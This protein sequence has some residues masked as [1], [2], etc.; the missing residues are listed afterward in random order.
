MKK[1]KKRSKGFLNIQI[2]SSEGVHTCVIESPGLW[3]N[4]EELGNIVKDLRRIVE[5]LGIGDLDYGIFT[6]SKDSLDRGVITVIYDGPKKN[7]LAFNSMAFIPCEIQG[8]PTPVLHLGLTVVDP[9]VQSKGFTWTLYGLSTALLLLKNR[10]RPF[11]I[12]S[13]TQVPVV[14]GKVADNLSE[15]YPAATP[16]SRRTFQHLLLGRQIMKYH[17]HVFGVGPDAEFDEENFIICNAYTGGSDHLK[18]T[19]KECAQYRHD[20]VNEFCLKNLN[21]QRGDDFL[22]IGKVDLNAIFKYVFHVI[23]PSR[24]WTFLAR[25]AQVTLESWIAPIIQWFTPSKRFNELRPR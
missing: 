16:D 8:Q 25:A 10:L 3:M 13:V 5:T 1:N 20:R 22:Q 2:G 23:P 18:K 9:N 15:V 7:P 6:G 11:W 21:Y 19:F 14:F 17:R 4:E 12:S 24:V